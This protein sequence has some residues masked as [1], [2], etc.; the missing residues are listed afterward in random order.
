MTPYKL[1]LISCLGIVIGTIIGSGIFIVP[2]IMIQTLPSPGLIL[3][4][5]IFSAAISITGVYVIAGMG[6]AYPNARDLSDYY[7]VMFPKWIAW[8]FN[9]VSVWIINPCG[10]VAIAFVFAEY[11]SYFFP[12]GSLGIKGVAI[13]L[14]FL[15]TVMD[16]LNTKTGDRFQ[17]LF[18][19]VKV[20]ALILLIGMLLLPGKGNISNFQMTGI[21]DWNTLKIIGAFFAASTGALNALDGWYM[22]SHVTPEV[23]G[24]VKTVKKAMIL[25]LL[26]CMALYLLTAFAYQYI[27][28]P[29]EMAS[30]KLVAITALEKELGGMAPAIIAIMVLISTG[31]CVNGNLIAS[32]RLMAS[33]AE[34]KM[35]P[36]ILAKKSKQNIPV[37]AFI[38]LF[39]YQSF[40]ILTGS[41]ELFLEM[42]VFSIWLFITILTAG[43]L[44]G[45]IKNNWSLE[46]IRRVPM[47]LAC[48]LLVVF[49]IIY[50]LNFFV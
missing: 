33:A 28:T 10:S 14:V 50:L 25:G 12:M 9:Q 15:L 37:N 38:V 41:Y 31:S 44:K 40:L 26:I 19:T 49:G 24:G 43:F 13:V 23:E 22:V 48:T 11:F 21:T 5:W 17:V 47:I 35:L 3:L 2:S 34:Q 6:M 1:N 8:I 32:S 30:S 4:V 39:F 16:A 42:S 20:G 27:L 46:G 29:E 7:R 45:F 36:T 18:T